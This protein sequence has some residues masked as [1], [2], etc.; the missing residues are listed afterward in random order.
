MIA[1]GGG[2]VE[3]PEVRELLRDALRRRSSTSTSRRP[4][5]ARA[6]AT[7]RSRGTRRSF[8]GATS[9]ACRSTTRSPTRA[10]ATPTTSSS[11]QQACTSRSARSSGSASSSRDG[12]AALVTEPVVAGIHGADA[13]LAL[14]AVRR[15][16]R[17]AVGRAREAASR[18]SSA[19]GARSASA[20]TGRSSRS[21]A[22]RSPTPPA[23]P[24]RRTSAASRGS[25][26]RRRSIGQ[27][28]AAIGGK[29]AIDLPEGK[30]LVGAFHWP[31]RTVIDPA[32]L[33][34]LP[35]GR[36][37]ERHGRGREDRAA[38][39]R[40]AVGAAGRRARPALRRV[41][42]GRLPP[43]P[44]RRGAARTCSTSGTRSRTRSRPPRAT[45]CPHGR[46]VALGLLAALRLSGRDDRCRRRASC[47]PSRCASTASAR[48]RR[49]SATRKARCA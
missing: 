34:T 35:R 39:G 9:C 30:N 3:T 42:V 5:S 20:A 32:L 26:C 28:D 36:A 10:H 46:A 38:R 24:P 21:A 14:G 11:P 33:E 29:T 27:V 40:A 31:A 37:P 19:S 43:R 16:A 2:A 48:G 45:T 22:A 6:A 44:A 17:A 1:I 13:Q 18:K 23:S 49:C 12:P 8:A 7:G 41:Q 15:D 4:G 47:D 25:P